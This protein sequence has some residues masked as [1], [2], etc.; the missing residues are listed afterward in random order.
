[1]D[2]SE[3]YAADTS[4]FFK[5]YVKYSV[6]SLD[7]IAFLGQRNEYEKYDFY[8]KPET[9]LYQNDRYMDYVLNYYKLYEAQLS[10]EV[11]ERFYNGVINSSP[12]VIMN[13]L[14]GDYALK[15]VRLRELVMIKM[16]SE[17]FFTDVYPQT[18]I[19]TILDSVSNNALFSEHK[20]IASNLKYR[21]LDLVPGTKMPDYSFM[22][23]GE[24]KFGSDYAGK[25]VYIQLVNQE[26]RKSI[27]DI[28]LL[29]PIQQKYAKHIQVLTV[30]VVDED[31]ALLK[32]PSKFI[33]EHKITWDLS[34]VTK[35]DPALKKLNVNSYPHYVLAD[36]SGHVVA[37]PA[38]S[39]RPNNEYE[40]IENMFIGIARYYRLMGKDEE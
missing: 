6:A 30:L 17:V 1:M 20:K 36:A 38:L 26:I 21:L 2:V 7:N 40:T 27:E 37:V 24:R 15:N 18:N 14:G 34:V 13:A 39:P 16:L 8:I 25:H 11:N 4:R 9:V 12:T 5:A 28:T 33:K 31:D 19:L 3:K 22:V 35:D 23:N 29:K 32:D 10:N